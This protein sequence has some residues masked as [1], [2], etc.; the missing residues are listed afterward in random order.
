MSGA[1]DHVLPSGV[2]RTS[3]VA[4]AEDMANW[5]P[6]DGG[7][8]EQPQAEKP[9]RAPKKKP[10]KGLAVPQDRPNE[11]T[12]DPHRLAN[13]FLRMQAT[14]S[15]GE[16]TLLNHRDDFHEHDGIRYLSVTHA[17]VKARVTA[18]IKSQ[19]DA[20][21]M[22]LQ[23]HP[24]LWDS[25]ELPRCRRVTTGVVNNTMAALESLTLVPN[26]ID[27]PAWLRGEQWGKP[28]DILPT[29]SGLLH[30]PRA[31]LDEDC[32]HPPTARF[33]TSAGV[34]YAFDGSAGCPEWIKFLLSLW[35]DDPQSVELLQEWIGYL[36]SLDGRHHK[37]LMLIGPPRS[38]KGTIARII[39][40]LL[41]M[42]S[43]ASPTLGSLA[44]PFGLWPLLGKSVAIVADARLS[45]RTDAIAVVKR[46]LSISGGD[47]QDVHRKNMPTLAA[48]KMAVRF[49][50]MSNELPNLRDASGAMTSRILLAHMPRSFLGHEDKGLDDRLA[51]ELPGILNWSILGWH[52]LRERGAFVQ[53]DSAKELLGELE[54]IASPISQFVREWCNVGPEYSVPV[55]S[56][57][58]TFQGWCKEHGR[59]QIPTKEVFGKDLRAHLPHIKKTQPRGEN[60][61]MNVYEGI[62][63]K[64]SGTGWH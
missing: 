43:V 49:M 64:L 23:Q 41:G 55:D 54:D 58:A 19:F 60:G 42:G 12:D 34:D 33:Y 10:G 53:P 39:K 17:E 31:L 61:R 29:R 57:F 15:R 25:T 27:A 21:N 24:E 50:L 13:A 45:G 20:E 30:L 40:L 4:T 8:P 22:H 28:E 59:D 62:A 2:P 51:A 9:K 7:I 11:G 38:G 37:I 56:V 1:Y 6:T 63:L 16:R 5:N 47:P 32:L 48:I 46:L 14:N 36:L 3:R 44:G 35:P 26:S 18:F 52:R